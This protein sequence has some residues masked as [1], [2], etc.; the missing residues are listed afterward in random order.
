VPTLRMDVD[1]ESDLEQA[2]KL[3]VGPHTAAVLE[4]RPAPR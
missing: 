3:G 2:R 4:H 1:T